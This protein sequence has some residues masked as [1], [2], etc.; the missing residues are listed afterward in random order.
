[1]KKIV[2]LAGIIL[3]AL[4]VKGWAEDAT[5]TSDIKAYLKL[6]DTPYTPTVLDFKKFYGVHDIRETRLIKLECQ[7]RGWPEPSQNEA[8]KRQN[9]CDKMI[10]QAEANASTTAS[11]FLGWLRTRLPLSPKLKIVKV[12]TV[13]AK[14]DDP[15]FVPC[16]L[17]W[18]KLDKV[19]VVFSRAI[20]DKGREIN[21][22]I[23]ITEIGGVSVD[24]LFD[25]YMKTVEDFLKK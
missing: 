25:D 12:L 9:D 10:L 6:L 13:P 22:L 2:L 7:K 16:E 1:M 4:V 23:S 15:D 20:D 8:D 21:G 14:P 17:V 18:A 5:R 11:L 3:L 24:T 19:K